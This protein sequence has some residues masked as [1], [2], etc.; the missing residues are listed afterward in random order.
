MI[1]VHEKVQLVVKRVESLK[2]G[3]YLRNREKLFTNILENS[4][5]TEF[6][7]ILLV[8]RYLMNQQ[9]IIVT[10]KPVNQILLENYRKRL[11]ELDD[12]MD[13]LMLKIEHS[14]DIPADIINKIVGFARDTVNPDTISTDS[15]SLHL[16]DL[17]EEIMKKNLKE[18][19]S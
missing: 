10:T 19:A 3:S 2:K 14:D 16:E 13:Q 12:K 15:I 7:G 18:K 6:F 4:L 17:E 9:N 11:Q 5:L 8:L 1:D